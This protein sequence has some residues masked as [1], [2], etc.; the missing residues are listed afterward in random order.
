MS[1]IL[2]VEDELSLAGLLSDVLE[3]ENYQVVT[4][5]NGKDA[6][7]YALRETPNLVI[8]DSF[9][10]CTDAF[11]LISS[12]RN[13]PKT[14]HI[15]LILISEADDAASKVRAFELGVDDYITLPF[16][17][18]ELCARI[19]SHLR[20]IQRSFLSPLVDLPGGFQVEQAI[21]YK[22][23]SQDPWS[24]L[25]LDLDNFKAFND[26]Y[27]FLSGNDLI[28]LVGRI[29]YEVVRE[30]GRPD[31]FLGH[32][33]GDDFVIVTS[34]NEATTLSTHI[35]ER[36]RHES[37]FVYTSDD[38]ER[39]S[40]MGLDRKGHS[41]QFPLVSLSIGVVCNRNRDSHSIHEVSHLAAEAKC[42]AKQAS[43][44]MYFYHVSS[45]PE[46]SSPSSVSKSALPSRSASLSY[47]PNRSLS[48]DFI[49]L[50]ND[51]VF[52]ERPS[53]VHQ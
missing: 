29:C 15:P 14:M 23:K 13:H 43:N 52:T 31:D 12:L 35:L 33:G 42:H 39:G 38:L 1:N 30:Y 49:S 19:R 22:L 3:H 41:F 17:Q 26:S 50:V 34:P 5:L 25:Y 2:V 10:S 36:Y 44:N 53:P 20:R 16:N 7:Q 18:P 32:V 8:L 45:R 40:I 37:R 11:S 27:G 51:D 28:R 4:V 48:R 21:S 6:V 9:L 46:F 47:I 24:I